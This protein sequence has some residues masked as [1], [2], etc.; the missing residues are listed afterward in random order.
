M[1]KLARR[2]AAVSRPRIP[3]SALAFWR[4]HSARSM[5]THS[6]SVC[7]S[8]C[9]P[10]SDAAASPIS[11]KPALISPDPCQL[12]RALPRVE[13][14]SDPGSAASTRMAA[15]CVSTWK[16]ARLSDIGRLAAFSNS[17]C[18]VFNRN[19]SATWSARC[20]P[21]A[22]ATRLPYP[23]PPRLPAAAASAA[24]AAASASAQPRSP[25][26]SCGVAE[27]PCTAPGLRPRIVSDRQA[28]NFA[29][30][31]LVADRT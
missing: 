29:R 23:G 4:T 5:L 30:R 2:S 17:L 9:I 21:G 20:C 13:V 7:A 6:A 15:S 12:R 14:C 3:L 11:A 22:S 8:R 26:C 31:P 27:K 18:C 10:F 16:D 28:P 19:L 25:S 24:A 1:D